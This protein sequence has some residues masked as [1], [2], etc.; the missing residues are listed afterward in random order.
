MNWTANMADQVAK[1]LRASFKTVLSPG[2]I[3]L[4]TEARLDQ[5]KP[6]NGKLMV[7]GNKGD[8]AERDFDCLILAAGFGTDGSGDHD[9]TQSYWIPDQLADDPLE[10]KS[11]LISGSGDGALVDLTRALVKDFRHDRFLDY[12]LS[13][14]GIDQIVDEMI[15]IED[16]SWKEFIEAERTPQLM[17]EY[18]NIKVPPNLISQIDQEI[19]TDRLVYFNY[20]RLKFETCILN[21]LFYLLL[22]NSRRFRRLQGRI[23]VTPDT[24]TGGRFQITLDGQLHPDLFD[25]IIVRH[26]PKEGSVNSAF[27]GLAVKFEAKAKKL[28]EEGLLRRY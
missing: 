27:P 11:L 25:R 6:E 21:R 12:V 15:E 1:E 10:D 16:R 24:A 26:G 19:R 18:S 3:S 4:T 28:K 9:R 22:R 14:P 5:I 7:E 8:L 13:L 20:T 17:A 2:R 23:V